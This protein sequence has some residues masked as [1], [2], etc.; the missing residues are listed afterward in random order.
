VQA[1]LGCIAAVAIIGVCAFGSG[2]L[3]FSIGY[4]DQGHPGIGWL[5]FLALNVIGIGSVIYFAIRNQRR[6]D[7]RGIA[8]GLWMG[9]GLLV[10]GLCFGGMM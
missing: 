5:V 6:P 2:F 4:G 9:I 7:R 1:I 10:V 3:G 8:I